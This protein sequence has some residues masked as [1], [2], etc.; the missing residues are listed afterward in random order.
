M[1][2]VAVA[3][4]V[5]GYDDAVRGVRA[6]VLEFVRSTWGGLEQFRDADIDRWVGRVV[7]IVTGGQRTV[8]SLT[9]AYL[10]AIEQST[11]GVPVPPRGV[12]SHLVTTEAMRGIS[13]AEVYR[14]PAVTVY[15]ALSKGAP[16]GQ[17]V[18]QGL[19]RAL[20]IAGTDVQ[21]ARTHSTR[22]LLSNNDRVVGYRRVPGGGNV[23][24]LCLT[25]ATQRY[26][27][28]DLMPI[29]GGCS[30]GVEPIFGSEDP[31]Q[32][33]DLQGAEDTSTE[34]FG[35]A[36]D[37]HQHGELGPVLTVAGQTF[38]GPDDLDL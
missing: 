10:A 22:Y 20:S 29:H 24:D 2:D 35:A 13:A 6:R 32:V 23:C 26:H 5:N 11:L 16:F 19:T 31:G 36:V 4:I 33:I 1:A 34:D 17:A 7:P 38:T 30:C 28:E 27:S 12:P 8:A 3:H 15:T 21:L 37:V 18:A 14:R 9:D 25:A